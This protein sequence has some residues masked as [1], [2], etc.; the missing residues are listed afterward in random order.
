MSLIVTTLALC[1]STRVPNVVH[2]MNRYPNRP[3]AVTHERIDVCS[4][5]L[6]QYAMVVAIANAEI[7]PDDLVFV[8]VLE[9]TRNSRCANR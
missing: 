3:F 5:V 7:R 6:R 2:N 4:V 1:R 9:C 8:S